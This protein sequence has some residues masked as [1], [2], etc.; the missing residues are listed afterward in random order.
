MG[1]PAGDCSAGAGEAGVWICVE[2][3]TQT[4]C[5]PEEFHA[6]GTLLSYD[7]EPP[8][9]AVDE[10]WLE[11]E[12][13]EMVAR[14][15]VDADPSVAGFQLLCAD[16]VGNPISSIGASG[17]SRGAYS[18]AADLCSDAEPTDIE[19]LRWA[20]R[21]SETLLANAREGRVLGL[22][23]DTEVEVLLVAYDR[24]GNPVAASE[25]ELG[26][27]PSGAGDTDGAQAG[28]ELSGRGC[29]CAAGERTPLGPLLILLGGLAARTMSRR[30]S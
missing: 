15:S 29:G 3:G 18:T 10:L 14:W 4:D 16:S 9:V 13:G 21:C 5:Q 20:Y 25:V 17:P 26:R 19:S 2:D 27:S 23:A 28:G 11:E 24:A 30:K 12:D 6:P 7:F 1:N 22:P 8:S